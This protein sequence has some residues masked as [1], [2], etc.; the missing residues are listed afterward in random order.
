MESYIDNAIDILEL[1]DHRKASTPIN[2]PIDTETAP[3][4][5]WKHKRFLTALGMLGWLAMTVRLDVAYAYSRIAQHCATPTESA[6]ATVYKTFAYLRDT[7]NLCLSAQIFDGDIDTYDLAK[8][9]GEVINNFRFLVDADHAGNQEVQNKRKSQNGELGLIN[10]TPFYWYSKTSSVAFAS[11]AIGEAHADTSSGAV[12]TYA[13][14][15][16]TQN[17]LGRSY[18]A[19][20]MGMNFPLPFTLEMDNDAARI[21]CQGSAQKTKLKHI[22]CRQEWVRTLRDRNV[23]IPKHIPTKENFADIFT[24]ILDK[25]TFEHLRDQLMHPYTPDKIWEGENEF[26]AHRNSSAAGL[27]LHWIY[28]HLLFRASANVLGILQESL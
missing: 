2:N 21:F 9:Q 7:K 27:I 13:A 16:A 12:E 1:H 3:L 28:V 25:N 5:P 24:K 15:N 22:D 6:L 19:E 4:P 8:L 10:E 20:E 14:G 26:N 11:A 18:V 23:M 17:I